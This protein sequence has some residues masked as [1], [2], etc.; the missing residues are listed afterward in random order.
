MQNFNLIVLYTGYKYY[1]TR[2]RPLDYKLHPGDFHR[3]C[4]DL[5]D[6]MSRP[7]YTISNIRASTMYYFS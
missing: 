2:R 1:F 4:S 5:R 7:L 3:S 6:T